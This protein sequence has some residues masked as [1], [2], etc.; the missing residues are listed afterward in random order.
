MVLCVSSKKDFEMS[1]AARSIIWGVT[2]LPFDNGYCH[3]RSG[4]TDLMKFNYMVLIFTA[5]FFPL[6]GGGSR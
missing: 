2:Q 5:P 3:W 4:H 1:L 6:G